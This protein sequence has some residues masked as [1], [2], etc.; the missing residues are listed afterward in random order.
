MVLEYA[1][2]FDRYSYCMISDKDRY[3]I[4]LWLSL[5][6]HLNDRHEKF[7]LDYLL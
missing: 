1:Y 5:K 2:K 3:N 6:L 4:S 7:P